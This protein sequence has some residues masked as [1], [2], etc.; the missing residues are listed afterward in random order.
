[1]STTDKLAILTLLAA[2]FLLPAILGA[3]QQMP[4]RRPATPSVTAIAWDAPTA[5]PLPP[6]LG[7][8]PTPRPRT[9]APLL[10]LDLPTPNPWA[11]P[12]SAELVEQQIARGQ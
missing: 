6:R 10:I 9:P 3:A 5:T 11:V 7:P 12:A 4:Q 8:T 1:M 2:M